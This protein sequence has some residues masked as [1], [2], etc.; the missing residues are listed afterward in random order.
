MRR[1]IKRAAGLRFATPSRFAR[2]DRPARMSRADATEAVAALGTFVLGAADLEMLRRLWD[3]RGGSSRE[4]NDGSIELVAP[5]GE[6]VTRG[7]PAHIED[8]LRARLAR[9]DPMALVFA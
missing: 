2:P 7:T 3:R 9:A 4:Y 8:Q 5:N 6:R 1:G